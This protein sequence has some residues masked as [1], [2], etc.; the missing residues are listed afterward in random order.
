MSRFIAKLPRLVPA[1]TWSDKKELPRC[2]R[3]GGRKRKVFVRFFL[4]ILYAMTNVRRSNLGHVRIGKRL[5]T[6]RNVAMKNPH[7]GLVVD[8]SRARQSFVTN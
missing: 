2:G 3:S 4:I 6:K 7:W 8:W 5:R 1:H